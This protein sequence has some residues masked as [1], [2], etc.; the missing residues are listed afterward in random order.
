LL[1]SV[2][3]SVP[4]LV[5]KHTLLEYWY[6][7]GASVRRILCWAIHYTS[8]SKNPSNFLKSYFYSSGHIKLKTCKVII[9]HF[10]IQVIYLVI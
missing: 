5:H 7:G 8:V 6:S 10:S 3:N 4:G 9:Q 2:W 1:N